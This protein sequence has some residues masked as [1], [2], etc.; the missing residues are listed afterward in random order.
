MSVEAV[1]GANWYTLQK[2]CR[3]R[4]RVSNQEVCD[5]VHIL[6]E[7][8]DLLLGLLEVIDII[9]F[10]ALLLLLESLLLHELKLLSLLNL[11]AHERLPQCQLGIMTMNKR[12]GWLLVLVTMHAN[13]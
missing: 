3:E 2:F 1:K 13:I 7:G 12:H 4:C 6:L 8:G 11:D 10:L 5:G 9:F